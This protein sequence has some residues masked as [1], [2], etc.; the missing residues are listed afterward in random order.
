MSENW[1]ARM[2]EIRAKLSL[3]EDGLDGNG[4]PLMYHFL[5]AGV[6]AS[7]LV[8]VDGSFAIYTALNYHSED[9]HKRVPELL[10]AG[11]NPNEIK[12]PT[13]LLHMAA[14]LHNSAVAEALLKAGA[15]WKALDTD[16]M[17]PLDCAIRNKNSEAIRVLTANHL[18][19]TLPKPLIANT[20][21]RL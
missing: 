16:G 5:K 4:E 15:D 21:H 8:K 3:D 13:T 17:T 12:S 7:F 10:A 9:F 6:P 18:E 14:S 1:E 11:V 19:E 2:E 20:R